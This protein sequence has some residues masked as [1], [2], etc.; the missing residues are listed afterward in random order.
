MFW[1][2]MVVK[3]NQLEQHKTDGMGASV[4]VC[5]YGCQKMADKCTVG[6]AVGLNGDF[7]KQQQYS[8]VGCW[9][10]CDGE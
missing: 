7:P 5:V 4:Y 3:I 8:N 1:A 9:K 10:K 6:R 2:Y